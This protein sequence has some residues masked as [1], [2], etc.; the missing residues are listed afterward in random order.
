MKSRAGGI[1]RVRRACPRCFATNRL[2]YRT[3]VQRFKPRLYRCNECGHV[4]RRGAWYDP[5]RPAD[6]L[7]L[8]P[9]VAIEQEKRVR[10]AHDAAL[11]LVEAT[12]AVWLKRSIHP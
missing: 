6:S 1:K 4:A 3:G 11:R 5:H 9:T 2:T 10:E 7:S 12:D 8:T